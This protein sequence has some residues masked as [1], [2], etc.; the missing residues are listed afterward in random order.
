[1]IRDLLAAASLT[2]NV[3]ARAVYVARARAEL[4]KMRAEVKALEIVV[5]AQEEELGRLA[6]QGER[7]P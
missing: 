7:K 4:E 2:P 1:M 6:A 3:G 5:G